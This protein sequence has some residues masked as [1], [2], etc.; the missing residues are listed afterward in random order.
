M[1]RKFSSTI[2][3]PTFLA[4][5]RLQSANAETD[6]EAIERGLQVAKEHCARCHI[7]DEGNR[8][9]GIASTPSFKTLVTALDDWEARFETFYAR[10]PHQ[11][12]VRIA[13]VDAGREDNRSIAGIDLRLADVEDLMAYVRNYQAKVDQ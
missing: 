1:T 7:V 11:S 5:T 2:A 10:N 4:M 9:S 12:V 6:S 8:F 3:I 13:E